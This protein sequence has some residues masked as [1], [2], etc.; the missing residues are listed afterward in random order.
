MTMKLNEHALKEQRF[1]MSS[2]GMMQ[3]LFAFFS[4]GFFFLVCSSFVLDWWFDYPMCEICLL[5]RFIMLLLALVSL[6]GALTVATQYKNIGI[7]CFVLTGLLIGLGLGF[8]ISHVYMLLKASSGGHS[9]ACRMVS[10]MTFIP[11]FWYDFFHSRYS[12]IPCN[13]VR[14][15]FLGLGFP[16]WSLWIYVLSVIAYAVVTCFAL[17]SYF[18]FARDVKRSQVVHWVKCFFSFLLVIL[19]CV[20]MAASI[21]FVAMQR[22]ILY[23]PDRYDQVQARLFDQV[24][25]I[26]YKIDAGEQ[27]AYGYPRSQ[28]RGANVKKNLWIALWGRDA[29]ALDSLF[30]DSAW[31]ELFNRLSADTDF[32]LVDY[33][34]FGQNA[35]FPAERANRDAVIKAY[36]AWRKYHNLAEDDAVRVFILAHSMGT[37]VAVDVARSLSEINGVV[38]MS[39]FVSIFQMSKVILGSWMAW[40]VRPFLLDR[41]PTADR[42]HLLHTKFPDLPVAIFH[43]VDDRVIP[44]THSQQIADANSWIQYYERSGLGHAKRD[45]ADQGIVDVMRAMMQLGQDVS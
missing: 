19:F 11:D 39:P 36:F 3:L 1:C 18:G 37:G 9:H 34:G 23:K 13:Q 43:G 27:W 45:F 40:T 24:D 25:V 5:Q 38:L 28:K 10:E 21:Y 4:S 42:L 16:W 7:I 29:M 31:Y 12:F 33:P 35:G 17:G 15:T 14:S 30:S 44:V 2:D 20:W 26:P 6:C 41:Y 32:L 8:S 22:K